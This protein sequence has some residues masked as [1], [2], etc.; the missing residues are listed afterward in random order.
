M[1]DSSAWYRHGV[2]WGEGVMVREEASS[3]LGHRGMTVCS[4]GT[5]SSHKTA[6]Y[7][8]GSPLCPVQ[9]KR[10]TELMLQNWAGTVGITTPR[11]L[12]GNYLLFYVIIYGFTQ[13]YTIYIFVFQSQCN[14][15]SQGKVTF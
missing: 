7:S 11:T 3:H 6:L 4:D 14:K 2:R 10:A 9:K 5:S 15:P 12:C 8:L 13:L 1:L